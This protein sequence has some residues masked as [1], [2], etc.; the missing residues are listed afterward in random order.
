MIITYE[1]KGVL[2]PSPA[3]TVMCYFAAAYVGQDMQASAT[4]GTLVR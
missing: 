1:I 3:E 2:P 4:S